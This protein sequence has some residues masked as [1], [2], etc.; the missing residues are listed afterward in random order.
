M[1]LQSDCFSLFS[2]HCSHYLLHIPCTQI[3]L[4]DKKNTSH[5]I[6]LPNARH[7]RIR[8]KHKKEREQEEENQTLEE[9]ESERERTRR[10]GA[11]LQHLLQQLSLL[12]QPSQLYPQQLFQ[13]LL[14]VLTT[15]CFP[16]APL[17]KRKQKSAKKE[18]IQEGRTKQKEYPLFFS[19]SSTWWW[20]GG[21]PIE[22]LGFANLHLWISRLL[23]RFRR[24]KLSSP[25]CRCRRRCSQALR[26]CVPRSIC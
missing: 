16:V 11:D 14:A 12:E 6:L 13:S 21:N 22:L 25:C 8:Q 20:S 26:F 17:A 19:S 18:I 24:F 7:K 23:E 1:L 4:S 9:K 3:F 10:R 15:L 5:E 2:S